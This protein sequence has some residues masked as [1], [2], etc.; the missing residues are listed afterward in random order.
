MNSS[1]TR[2]LM[3]AVVLGLLLGLGGH[4]GTDSPPAAVAAAGTTERVSVSSSGGQA[5]A[6]S[7][8]S[9]ISG[10]G[11][12]VA[13]RSQATNL[14]AGD[15]NATGDIFVHDR[16]TGATTRVSVDSAGNEGNGGSSSPAI[17]GDGRFVAFQSA[18]TNLV[19]GDT[20]AIKDIFVHDR[21][22]G[23]TTRVSVDSAGA[24]ANDNSFR[25]AISDDGRFVAFRSDATNLV[26]GDTNGV[27]DVFVHDRQTGAT[28]RVSVDSAGAQGNDRSDNPDISRDGRFV[29]FASYA[30]NLVAGHINLCGTQSCQDTFVHD[31]Q[32]GITELVSV[33]SGGA[34]G[35]GPSSSP[36]I[37]G[38]G[39]FVVIW[40]LAPNLVPG[41]TNGEFDV[42]VHDRQTGTTERVNV[43]STG[44]QAN[45]A[46]FVGD[47]S[48][49][50]RLIGFYSYATNLVVGD[51]TGGFNGSDIF[52]HD[53]QTGATTRVSVDSAG[54][55]ANAN[56]NSPSLSADG[57]FIAFRSQATNLV[58]G[59]TNGVRD[60]FVHEHAIPP[61]P[62]FDPT[63]PLADP[64]HPVSWTPDPVNTASGDF[65]HLHTD[66]AIPGRGIPLDFTRSYHSG[67]D[68][69]RSLGQGWTHGFDMYLVF[70]GSDVTVF[71]PQGHAVI[72]VFSGGVYVPRPGVFDTF[73][74]NGDGTFT[75]TTVS[76]IRY[77]FSSAG[78]LTSIADRNDNT[79]TLTYTAGLLTS[80]TDPGG[81]SLTFSYDDVQHPNF[82]TKVT[83]PLPTPDTRTVE[84]TYDANGDLVQVTDV[85]GGTT[86]YAYD[87]H[88]LISLT[89]ANDHVAVQN[90]YDSAN[91]VV[92]QLD[93][94]AAPG[95]VQRLPLDEVVSAT[96]LTGATV[97][98]LDDDPDAD[99]GDWAT[100]TSVADT[101]LRVGFPTPPGDPTV[102]ADLQ[103]FRVLL[104][105][106]A[107]GGNDPTYDIELWET[108]GGAPLA[109]LASG[110][111]LSSDTG[112]VV[113]ATWDAS[114]L[115]TADGSAV[116]LVVVGNR[117]GGN[118]SKRRTVEVGALEWNVDSVGS[119]ANVTCL[120]YGTGP[121]Y[122][123]AACPG[124][125][126][127]PTAS[128]TIVVDARGNKTTHTFDSSFRTTDI[129]DDLGN[130]V[131]YD[132]DTDNDVTCITD[133][134]L[135]KTGFAYDTAG[136][137]TQIIDALNTDANCLLK[138]GGVDS[139]FTYTADNDI[140]LAT[141]PLGR[142]TDYIY[143]S[144]SNLTRIVRKD[145]GAVIKAL[146]CFERNAE[147]LMTALAESTDLVL[148]AG[149]TDP[150]T[151]NKTL[152]EYDANGN[153]TAVVDPRFSGQPTPP[154]TIFGPDSGG[155][156][157]TITNELS[158]TTTFTYD[159]QNNVLTVADNLGNTASNTYDAK[160]NLKTVTDANRQ[161]VSAPE[162]GAQ[163]GTAGTGDG[164]D[165][166]GDTVAD[167]GCPSAIYNYDD[168]DRLTEVI[169]ALGQST[170]Y[171]YDANGNRTTVTNARG[172]AT[173]NGY[174][175]VDRLESVTDPLSRVTSYQY[176]A[177]SNLT[178]RTDARG[179]VTKY[180]YDATNLLTDLDH[181]QSDGMT[182]VDSVDYTYDDVGNRLTMVDPTGTTIYVYDA[183]N[184]PKSFSFPGPNSVSY[185]YDNTGHR[186]RIT[187]PDTKFVDHTY[188]EAGNL[189]TAT[190]WLTKQT[191][192]TYDNARNLTKTALP[193]GAWTDFGYDTADRLTSVLNKNAGGTISSFTYTL[194]AV[195]NRT[196]MVDLS[197]TH[198]YDYDDLYRLEQVTYPD[199]QTDTYTYDP[200][201]NRL[202]RN[203][204]AYTYDDA[205]QMLTAGGVSYGY[206][207][208]GN[209][210]S[211]G[212]D[213]FTYD[214]ENRLAQSV[215]GV[216]TSSSVYNGDGL[217][218][219]H[220]EGVT[221]TSY[222]WDVVAGLP[223]VVQDDDNTYVYGLD[224]ISATDGAGVQ[225]YSLNDGLGST[226][227][228]TDG[229][230]NPTDD[231]SYDVFGTI[232]SQSGSSSN[233]WLFTGEQ[234]DGQPG[235]AGGVQ[236]LP[237]DVVVSSTNL[238]GATVANLDDDP[239][240]DEGDWATATSVADTSLRVGFPTPPGD[241]TVGADLQ[242][243]RVLLRKD[244]TGGNDPTYDIEL[245]ETGG[246]A[247]LATLVSGATLSSDTG[248]VVS[249]T[250]DA[251]LLGTSDGS[252]VE[253]KVVGDRS[254]GPSSKR[255]TVEVGAVEW[256]V[257][258][259]GTPSSELYYLRAR[260]YD[261]ETG[262]LLSQDPLPGGHPYAY[263][264]NNPVNFIDPTGLHC[265]GWH[266][267]HC[268]K[269][270]VEEGVNTAAD[271][272]KA[273]LDFASSD[274]GTALLCGA[275]PLGAPAV[276]CGI[277]ALLN[278]TTRDVVL[279]GVQILDV[280]PIPGPA[281][282]VIEFAAFFAAEYQILTNS[283]LSTDQKITLSELNA[284]NVSLGTLAKVLP[285]AEWVAVPY[286]LANLGTAT[287]AGTC[288]VAYSSGL[289]DPGSGK[290]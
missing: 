160:G 264:G 155:R 66:L 132:F 261:P 72:F 150:C 235:V 193:N 46:S 147:G 111:T 218:M 107:T 53:R 259:G 135:N 257:D 102:G 13:F 52:I 202:T 231:Y 278:P 192:Y 284:L 157:L 61:P 223:I 258:F 114:L 3:V 244:A 250:W 16:Q 23:A 45:D 191:V 173:T 161:P 275:V 144:T 97:E 267:H 228:L 158:H 210:T 151:G 119:S 266:P 33:D 37:S 177:A 142:Q 247:P 205:D 248:V 209:Q 229:S 154:K 73:V 201:G 139:T 211:R 14:V 254:N 58:L 184:R 145:A 6:T 164:V 64:N 241:P 87:N 163:C 197:G 76:E 118:P 234:R 109:T 44:A 196:Q 65:N 183:L 34:Q 78:V 51:T 226:T 215:I 185:Q 81:R 86:I 8:C 83:D 189:K 204:T 190:D 181:Y 43:S 24:Q 116:E 256:N 79:T 110:V 41:D 127:G 91:R 227:D 277:S 140:D 54:N 279:T 216:V 207:A 49:D 206:D 220:T 25:P 213:T 128:Q 60:I 224:L 230:A 120:Y 75:F 270:G 96:N 82:I 217:R 80:V 255:R 129:E 56:S 39:R 272:G 281:G 171:G 165:D 112:V 22:T 77:D 221:T 280:A 188:D 199:P 131:H 26:A 286:E 125:A 48:D 174:D 12:F 240:A 93:G 100:A 30:S 263:V 187:Y 214:H 105:K 68:T 5:N 7:C 282:V 166:D 4:V 133:Q 283:C 176:D 290:E 50:G 71:Y 162:T 126:P 40:S 238:T 57:R 288:Q 232:R 32:T 123:S 21:Q 146:T 36:A 90:I 149:P 179:L 148:P 186:S 260:Y 59:D 47:S 159:D 152:F 276:P 253:L 239:D 74:D 88:R 141:D 35:E 268:L 237:L 175:A 42:F 70:E 124:V 31:R 168:G 27:R 94:E 195:G 167:D 9:A 182:L 117:S 136:N 19:A 219:S 99:E 287:L 134:R 115:G 233:Y 104:R 172:K 10:D 95:G 245:W 121:T 29:A 289:G 153:Q 170:T 143:D 89:D 130:V 138:V 242:E 108:G 85:K 169:D 198:T 67:S 273:A 62:V 69:T 28:E 20:N 101:S 156:V 285:P 194:D 249:A 63:N 236:R 2:L 180:I 222:T 122:T 106:D 200:V 15:T 17:S 178:Q 265:K 203:A 84:F 251:S 271:I 55:E 274:I 262:R 225:T 18:A 113:S 103:E 269:E 98:N 38:N 11:R 137:V 208:N 212:S 1:V 92:E 243:F 252:A 246:G